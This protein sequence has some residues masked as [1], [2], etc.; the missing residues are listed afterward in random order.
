[1]ITKPFLSGPYTASF[2]LYSS[3]LLQSIGRVLL[4][5]LKA[6]NPLINIHKFPHPRNYPLPSPLG[7]QHARSLGKY[8]HNRMPMPT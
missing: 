6:A 5:S 3:L 4:L 2:S 1:M 7:L 8:S